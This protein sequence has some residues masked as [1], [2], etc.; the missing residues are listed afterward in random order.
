MLNEGAVAFKKKSG[1]FVPVTCM[2]I[3]CPRIKLY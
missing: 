1:E 3:T 2:E